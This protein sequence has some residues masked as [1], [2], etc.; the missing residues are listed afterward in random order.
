[1][2]L[3]SLRTSA[4][5]SCSEVSLRDGCSDSYRLSR[6]SHEVGRRLPWRRPSP[7]G[8]DQESA[9]PGRCSSGETSG[10]RPVCDRSGRAS[11]ERGRPPATPLR[12]GTEPGTSWLEGGDGRPGEA[13]LATQGISRVTPRR[14]RDDRYPGTRRPVVGRTRFRLKDGGE[15]QQE[16]AE[17]LRENAPRAR[18]SHPARLWGRVRGGAR[19]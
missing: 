3:D 5:T 4:Q 6:E 1:M 11:P 2:I 9:R 16:R 8:H 14:L 18:E 19:A 15:A 12:R 7:G 17:H 10:P 13:V